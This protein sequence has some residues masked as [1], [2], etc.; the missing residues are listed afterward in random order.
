MRVEKA[1]W[2]S[3]VNA[4]VL[5]LEARAAALQQPGGVSLYTF[6]MRAQSL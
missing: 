2:K 3:I 1:L 4:I 5:E 6:E